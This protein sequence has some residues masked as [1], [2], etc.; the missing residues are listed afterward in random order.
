MPVPHKRLYDTTK[1]YKKQKL[2]FF[3]LKKN[4]MCGAGFGRQKE[5]R[6]DTPGSF[7]NQINRAVS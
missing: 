2:T 4:L 5:V 3:I 6:F 7:D 1:K